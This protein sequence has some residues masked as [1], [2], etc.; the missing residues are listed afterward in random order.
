MV[1]LLHKSVKLADTAYVHPR[2]P[3]PLPGMKM[4]PK[5]RVTQVVKI[6]ESERRAVV[7]RGWGRE[8]GEL[9]FNGDRVCFTR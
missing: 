8:E 9:V 6:T 4:N 3:H 2:A 1:Q 7:A 5:R